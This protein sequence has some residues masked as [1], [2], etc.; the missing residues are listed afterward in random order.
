M[1]V[2]LGTTNPG[3]LKEFASLAGSENWLE[4]ELA[5]PDFSVQETGT[6]FFENAKIKASKAAQMTG[7]PALA[8]D[9]GLVI[10]A[11]KGKPGILS[12][13]YCEGSDAD[14]R[15][16]VLKEMEKVPEKERQAA[17]FCAMVL[18]NPDG[19]VAFSTIRC[20]EGQI[21]LEE[22]GEN[23][24]GYDSIFIL[25]KKQLSAAELDLEEKNRIS[26]RG[27]AFAQVLRFLKEKKC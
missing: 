18:A 10:E 4:L 19:S 20:W 2:V 7:L 9:S 26:H 11:L 21:A 13:R 15:A 17:F 16:K 23:G 8:D 6:T 3:K 25:P 24:F 1:K 27:Q 14:R 5:P 12:A 22:R